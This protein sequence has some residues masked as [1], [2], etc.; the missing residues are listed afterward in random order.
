[1]AV[2]GAILSRVVTV[3]LIVESS[4]C[5]MKNNPS[6]APMSL[7]VLGASDALKA[8][9]RARRSLVLTTEMVKAM[10]CGSS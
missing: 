10:E 4:L 6:K 7:P 1:M 9:V 3:M 8:F 2:A 5:V